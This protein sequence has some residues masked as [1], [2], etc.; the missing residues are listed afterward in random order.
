MTSSRSTSTL[1]E[2]VG[3]ET[4]NPSTLAYFSARN[5]RKIYSA[6]IKEFK[7]SKLTQAQLARRMGQRTDVICRWLSGPG[8]YTLDTVSN[9]LFGISG[10]ELT[11]TVSHPLAESPR[12]YTIPDWV[13]KLSSTIE[14]NKPPP[15]S[16]IDKQG[17]V[18]EP[19]NPSANNRIISYWTDV[20]EDH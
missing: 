17:G 4:I 10:G 12:N 6:V 9:L 19:L 14:G 18:D 20:N 1:A 15:P 3:D 13:N 7:K 11:Y 2:P 5:R 8:N 16:L